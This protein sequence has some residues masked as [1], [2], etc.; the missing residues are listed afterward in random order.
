MSS[1]YDPLAGHPRY[2]KIRSI[3]EVRFCDP[4]ARSIEV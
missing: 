2:R 3:N 1:I 4:E